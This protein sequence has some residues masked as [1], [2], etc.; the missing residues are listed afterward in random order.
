M[1][2]KKIIT[3]IVL[4]LVIFLA[5]TT[6]KSVKAEDIS[7]DEHVEVLSSGYSLVVDFYNQ[8]GRI[9]DTNFNTLY[10]VAGRAVVSAEAIKPLV[11]IEEYD[12]KYRDK[13]N[14][15]FRVFKN[16]AIYKAEALYDY[17]K[18]VFSPTA[19]GIEAV[20]LKL[21]EVKNLIQSATSYQVVVDAEQSFNDYVNSDGISKNTDKIST[22]SDQPITVKLT[23]SEMVFAESDISV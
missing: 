10:E 8:G 1:S 12:R 7:I 14:D 20:N 22:G 9:D 21:R 19:S 16:V 11:T 15:V 18:D 17:Y 13:H 23:S 5:P 2:F 3:A 6:F 4:S